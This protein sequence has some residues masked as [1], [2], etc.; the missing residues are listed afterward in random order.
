MDWSIISIVNINFYKKPLNDNEL[1]AIEEL[2]RKD[3][4]VDNLNVHPMQLSFY[5]WG[6][7]NVNYGI[8][9]KAKDKLKEM[10]FSNF[11]ILAK[12]YAL[13]GEGYHYR[14]QI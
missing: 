10:G 8:L 6:K 5:I 11:E 2:F 12:K 3:N 9:D 13:S 4:E 1:Q 7:K 14:S